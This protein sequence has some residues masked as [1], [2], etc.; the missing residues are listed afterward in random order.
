M[1]NEKKEAERDQKTGREGDVERRRSLMDRLIKE[2]F[3]RRGRLWDEGKGRVSRIKIIKASWT[4][5]LFDD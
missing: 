3:G 4:R 5:V 1:K 2:D